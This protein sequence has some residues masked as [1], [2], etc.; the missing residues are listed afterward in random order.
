MYPAEFGGKASALINVATKAGSNAF[1]GS[2]FAFHRNDAFDSPN[3]F[4]PANHRMPPLRQNQYGGA[5][6][7]PVV[8]NRDVFL[9]QLR[10]HA[11]AAVADAHVLRADRPPYVPGIFQ[12]SATIC[13]PIAIPTTGA[14]TPFANNQ[15]PAS[16][17]DPIATAFLQKVPLPT[18]GA[19][20]QNLTAVE[21]STREVDQFSIRLDHRLTERGSVLRAF[22]YLRRG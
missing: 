7:G 20:L 14:C 22:Q 10:R 15:I 6:G 17:I 9:W 2:L 16:R 8:Q 12:G 18:S 3:Y 11:D 21:E 19:A 13:D 4:Q 1:S 5:L